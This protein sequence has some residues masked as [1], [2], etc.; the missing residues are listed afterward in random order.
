MSATDTSIALMVNHHALFAVKVKLFF[1]AITLRWDRYDTLKEHRR[2]I[3]RR[4]ARLGEGAKS[5]AKAE[6]VE[7]LPFPE[8]VR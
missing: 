6:Q 4:E 7:A 3:E 2:I 1:A 5:K 8:A